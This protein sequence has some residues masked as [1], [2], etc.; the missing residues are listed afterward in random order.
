MRPL[1]L[2][3]LVLAASA[4][5]SSPVTVSS[6]RVADQ[7]AL[8]GGRPPMID[9]AL[10]A[11]PVNFAVSAAGA[12]RGL[13]VASHELT[14]LHEGRV[15][16]T[17]RHAGRRS[18]LP[19]AALPPAVALTLV[20]T[21]TTTTATAN[22]TAS[23]TVAVRTSLP[24]AAWDASSQWIGTHFAMLRRTFSL[25]AGTAT[26]GLQL[27]IAGLGFFAVWVNGKRIDTSPLSGYWT[28]WNERVIYNSFQLPAGALSSTAPNAIGV[29]LG[30]GWRNTTSFPPHFATSA[31]CDPLFR[32]LRLA[33]TDASGKV[34]LGSDTQ[35]QGTAQGPLRFSSVYDGS[36]YDARAEQ[37]GWATASFKPPADW[38]PAV[39]APCMNATTMSP[40]TF[41]DIEQQSI[42]PAVNITTV[43]GNNVHVLDFG[44][45]K[46]GYCRLTATGPAG[47]TIV[48]RHAEALMHPPYGPVDGTIYTGNLRSAQA[49]DTFILKGTGAPEVFEPMFTYHGFRY[50][51]MEG[52]PG[53][54]TPTSVQQIHFRTDA[55]V[56]SKFSSSSPV[57]NAIQYSALFSQGSNLMSVPTDCPQRDERLGWMGDAGLSAD[58]ITINYDYAAMQA[59]FLRSMAEDQLGPDGSLPDTVPYARYGNRPADGSWSAAFPQNLFVRYSINQDTTLARQYFPQLLT[60]LN[61][62][63]SQ[64]AKSGGKFKTWKVCCGGVSRNS[65]NHGRVW[66]W[67][68]KRGGLSAELF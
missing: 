27:H 21:T 5:A 7:E 59:S 18:T 4:H 42:A 14:V 37:P 52:Y 57:L 58:S 13:T 9:L 15:V 26:S 10:D 60:Y 28:T 31:S 30:G 1:A 34:V 19:T 51:Q 6:V 38:Q 54:P 62:I 41:P 11:V 39:A 55:A 12:V 68:R 25:P 16:H 64:I 49:T 29:M 50:V 61:N 53:T 20:I 56:R 65:R 43:K 67:R 23:A 63:K 45:N 2:L 48:L 47:T 40:L 35:W 32:L 33:V 22:H 44:H 46:A 8:A 66:V 36:T 3:V 17:A 24:S